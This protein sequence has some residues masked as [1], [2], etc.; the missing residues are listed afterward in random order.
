MLRLSLLVP[1]AIRYLWG[2]GPLLLLDTIID[3]NLDDGMID[4]SLDGHGVEALP[5]PGDLL[6]GE[7]AG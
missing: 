1:N 4:I 3:T 7:L 6:D 2:T 5:Y